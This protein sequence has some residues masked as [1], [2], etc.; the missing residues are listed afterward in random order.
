MKYLITEQQYRILNEE[1]EEILELPFK[2]F[3]NDW[4]LLQEY[5]GMIG[6]PPYKIIDN[7]ILRNIEIESFGNL[8]SIEGDLDMIRVKIKSLGNLKY[9]G[10]NFDTGG[11]EDPI[12]TVEIE[13]LENLEEVGGKLNLLANRTIKDLG[14]LRRVGGFMDLSETKIASLG[15]LEYVGDNLWLW[16]NK[17]IKDLGKLKY[18]GDTIILGKSL[19]SQTMTEKEI[20]QQVHV[21]DRISM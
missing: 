18:V 2:M 7:L 17:K 1:T 16:G 6:N 14:N 20:R 9:V 8:V 12:S 3:N 4:N 15:N 10:G 5:L 13:S 11:D 21:G 19:L